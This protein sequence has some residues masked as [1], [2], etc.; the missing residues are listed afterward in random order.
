MASGDDD[1]VSIS[2]QDISKKESLLVACKHCPATRKVTRQ[3]Y[4][5]KLLAQYH[6]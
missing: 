1:D 2:P 3:L 4:G 5:F 6:P